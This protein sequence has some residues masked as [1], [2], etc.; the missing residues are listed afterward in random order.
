M[1]YEII[2]EIRLKQWVKNLLIFLPAFFAGHIFS[3]NVYIYLIL[4][5]FAYSFIASS[6]YVINDLFDIEKDKLHPV[7]KNRPIAS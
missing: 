2:K 7:K 1:V 4:T 6:I 5:F 3:V